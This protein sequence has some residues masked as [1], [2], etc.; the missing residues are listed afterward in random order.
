MNEKNL[1]RAITCDGSA[2]VLVC[3]STEIV[4][5]ASE[6][7]RTSKTMTA[8]LGRALTAASLMGSMLKNEKNSLTLQFKCDGPAQNIV[9][10]SDWHGNVRGYADNPSAELPPNDKGKLDVGG[11]VGG[12][13]LYVI[14]DVGMNE[15]YVGMCPIE[16]GEIAEDITNYYARSEQTP[17]ACALGVLVDKDLTCL[18]AG[19]FMVQL[20]PGADDDVIT[21]IEENI[22]KIQPVSRMVQQGMSPLEIAS[23]VFKN[24]EFDVLDDAYVEYKCNCSREKYEKVMISLGKKE[25]EQLKQENEPV[26]TVCNFCNSKYVFSIDELDK[27][28]NAS[29]R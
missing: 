6:I 2:Y 4:N 25:L 1:V 24:I 29:K 15:P 23:E 16:S 8:A 22:S 20:L 21:K 3:N 5:K 7:H 13:T 26:E 9:C 17:T 19:G 11:V 18:A 12:G 10:V 27:M 14:R 28:I